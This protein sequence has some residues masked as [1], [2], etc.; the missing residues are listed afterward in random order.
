M[1]IHTS[2]NCRSTRPQTTAVV[3]P[4]NANWRGLESP[5]A[6]LPVEVKSNR[7][8]PPDF[9][10]LCLVATAWPSRPAVRAVALPCPCRAL[11]VLRLC[12]ALGAASAMS[13]RQAADTLQQYAP[14]LWQFDAVQPHAGRFSMSVTCYNSR[15]HHGCII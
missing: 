4:Q 3:L 7:G 2:F 1:L 5:S 8:R 13:S 11:A 10:R 12:Q 9:G 14:A 15:I 6:H